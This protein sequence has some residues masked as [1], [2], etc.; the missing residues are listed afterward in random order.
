M[1]PPSNFFGVVY[2]ELPVIHPLEDFNVSVRVNLTQ[3]L[4][5]RLGYECLLCAIPKVDIVPVNRF[6]LL[7][8]NV[9][10]AIPDGFSLA[11]GPHLLAFIQK[12]IEE[13]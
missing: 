13:M 4:H 1:N 7:S 9:L 3:M 8:I 6:Q 12:D 10:V 11:G 2:K 5:L